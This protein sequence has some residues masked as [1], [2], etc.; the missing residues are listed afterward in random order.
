MEIRNYLFQLLVEALVVGI[1]LSLF[2]L[3]LSIFLRKYNG[4]NYSKTSDLVKLLFVSGML[5]HLTCEMT[6]VNSWYTTHGATLR[7][8]KT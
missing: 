2:G 1:V 3:I 8:T 5:F 6:G 7:N 4:L